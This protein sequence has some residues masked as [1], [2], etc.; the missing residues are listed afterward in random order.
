MAFFIW[1]SLLV[2]LSCLFLSPFSPPSYLGCCTLLAS[3]WSFDFLGCEIQL[4]LSSART[5]FNEIKRKY[6]LNSIFVF[7]REGGLRFGE[8][9][10]D[11]QIAHGASQF[12]KERLFEVSDPY[13]VHVCNLCGL[14]CMA[15]LRTSTFECKGCLNKTQ[16]RKYFSFCYSRATSKR[17][18]W[19]LYFT[20]LD[21]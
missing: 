21:Q 8:M 13:S 5:S 11:C 19:L 12:L 17:G 6:V 2:S 14:M 7:Y 15:N 16:V 4:V 1:T 3:C 18:S 10:R 20:Q 9:E